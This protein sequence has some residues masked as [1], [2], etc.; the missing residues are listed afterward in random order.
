MDGCE[1][2]CGMVPYLGKYV[3]DQWDHVEPAGR[4]FIEATKRPGLPDNWKTGVYDFDIINP[5]NIK[6]QMTT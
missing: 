4:Y 1:R 2:L 5:Y 3:S 6:K